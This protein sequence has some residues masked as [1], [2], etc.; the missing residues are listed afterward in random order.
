MIER[1]NIHTVI[2]GDGDRSFVL[3]NGASQSLRSWD[4]VVPGL[5]E[6]GRVIRL[7]VPGVGAS[8]PPDEPYSFEELAEAVIDVTRS[9]VAGRLI[10]VGHAWGGRL[11]QVIARD[12]PAAVSG[13][14]I[15]S[16][17]GKFPQLTSPEDMQALVDARLANDDAAWGAAFERVYCA[18]GFLEREPERAT[19]LFELARATPVDRAIVA[20]AV[21]RTPA[22]SYWGQ[23]DCPALL[24]YGAEDQI[25]HGAN[26]E[27]L[28]RTLAHSKLV[29]IN[30]AGHF[31]VAE[32]PE[33]FSS[34]IS[35]WIEESG[36]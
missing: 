26:A 1:S 19:W 30:E 25:G 33:R 23:V 32:Q 5:L 4:Y 2:E 3:L 16:T 6:L 24:L 28:H 35:S 22:P 11:T 12:H 14:V 21:R 15:G 17:G 20:E 10:V 36:L 34:E 31:V 13:V 29:Y 9:H 18:A 8:P 27:D 7:D